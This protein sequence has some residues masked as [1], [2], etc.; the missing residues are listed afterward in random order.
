MFPQG[1][2][3]GTGG[4]QDNLPISL[5]GPPALL[6]VAFVSGLIR[7]FGGRIMEPGPSFEKKL[8]VLGTP[9]QY[10]HRPEISYSKIV[11]AA[12]DERHYHLCNRSRADQPDRFGIWWERLPGYRIDSERPQANLPERSS[13]ILETAQALR[14]ARSVSDN[15]RVASWKI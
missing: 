15:R 13:V 1:T 6:C 8:L 2:M 12:E 14:G 11:G 4:F 10:W 9:S 7:A 3:S 5:F